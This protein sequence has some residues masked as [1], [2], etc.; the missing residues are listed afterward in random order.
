MRRVPHLALALS[1]G[2]CAGTP[3]P[4]GT[5]VEQ[6]RLA[7]A[8]VPGQATRASVLAALGPTRSIAFDS[9]YQVWLYQAPQGNGLF[10][11]YVVLF[12]PSGVVSKT[13]QG[14]PAPAKSG[15]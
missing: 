1:L 12:D 15:K 10:S 9:G 6:A 8:T 2:A 3:P 14:A 13:R 11:E 7:A 5:Q 4:P